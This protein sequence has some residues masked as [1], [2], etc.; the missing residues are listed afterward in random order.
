MKKSI[1]RKK[2]YNSTLSRRDFMKMIGLGAAGAGAIGMGA[3]VLG[4]F[5]DLD[6]MMASPEAERKLPFWIKEVDKPTV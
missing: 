6:E 2:Q 1:P 5:K 3:P 4:S